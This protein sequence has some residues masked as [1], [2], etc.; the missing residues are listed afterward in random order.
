MDKVAFLQQVPIFS[1]L[2]PKHLAALAEIA[3]RRHYRKGQ[4]IFYRGD[5]G[6]AM[7]LLIKGSVMMTLPSEDGSEVIVAA[8]R[9]GDQF[10]ELAVVDGG[11][12]YVTT[13]ATEPTEVLAIY[14]E[15]LLELLRPHADAALAIALGLCGRLR[16][17]TDLLADIAFL[18]LLC[19]LAKRLCQLAGVFHA[20]SLETPDVHVSQEALA[21]MVGATREAVN[22][23]LAKLRE[24][25][26]IE[27]G[28]GYV[29]ILRPLRL[30]ALA[31]GNVT[32]FTLRA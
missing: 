28:R 14:R 21:E 9:P 20:P 4:T 31:V 11:V 18:N 32:D 7:Y 16:H 12:R 24:M 5:P 3:H 10:G 17:V 13:V 30:R 2:E 29:R 6:N 23:Q 22:K 8:V 25:G 15:N 19:R 27:T 1:A 26:L